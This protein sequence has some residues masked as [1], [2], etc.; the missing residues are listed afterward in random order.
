MN[1]FTLY[2][3]LMFKSESLD[4]WELCLSNVPTC[5]ERACPITKG[6]GL[7][8]NGFWGTCPFSLTCKPSLSKWS[9][10]PAL[11]N[12]GFTRRKHGS[13]F[14]GRGGAVGE[15]GHSHEV[16]GLCDQEHAFVPGG[17]VGAISTDIMW[18]QASTLGSRRKCQGGIKRKKKLLD[19]MSFGYFF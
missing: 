5:S 3:L 7:E 2:S 4:V 17:W 16:Q 19:L 6:T 12:W 11:P 18:C 1:S 8:G 13:W 15:G 9:Q 10:L 14:S